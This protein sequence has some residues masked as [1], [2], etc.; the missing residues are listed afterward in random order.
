MEKA[1]ESTKP[2]YIEVVLDAEVRWWI[3]RIPNGVTLSLRHPRLG[4][5]SWP[6][7]AGMV[8]AL[9][10]HLHQTLEAAIGSEPTPP[11]PNVH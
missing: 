8:K 1:D 5:V 2:P 4:W 9:T 10:D 6:L 3:A 11:P 7:S